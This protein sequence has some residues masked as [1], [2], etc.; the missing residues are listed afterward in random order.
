MS[1]RPDGCG[2]AE[3]PIGM[4][5][6]ADGSGAGDPSRNVGRTPGVAVASYF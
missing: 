1:M 4:S 6:A 2:D 3:R 5:G